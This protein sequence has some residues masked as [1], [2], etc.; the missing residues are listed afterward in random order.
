M[1]RF[2]CDCGNLLSNSVEPNVTTFRVYSQ[3][4]WDNIIKDDYIESIKIPFPKYDAWKC[5]ICNRIY[6]FDG[7]NLIKQYVLEK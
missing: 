3:S 2:L 7:G 4:E 1:A 5:P 6:I